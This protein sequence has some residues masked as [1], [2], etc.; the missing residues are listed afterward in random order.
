MDTTTLS[1][2]IPDTTLTFLRLSKRLA[3]ICA[4][5]VLVL[6][7]YYLPIAL[8]IPGWR[9]FVWIGIVL[10]QLLHHKKGKIVQNQGVYFGLWF[11]IIFIEFC[12][13]HNFALFF[14]LPVIFVFLIPSYIFLTTRG[15]YIFLEIFIILYA[16]IAFQKPTFTDANILGFIIV[17]TS[18]LSSWDTFS[19]YVQIQS[20]HV[21]DFLQCYRK[22]TDRFKDNL[23]N[24]W[25]NLL[26]KFD[27]ETRDHSL[28]VANLS[29][30]F[31]QKLGLKPESIQKLKREALLHDIGKLAIPSEVLFKTG[32]LNPEDKDAIKQHAYFSYKFIQNS[33]LLKD[34]RATTYAHHERWDGKG[35]PNGLKG[36][37]IPFRARVLSIAD[38]WDAL[39]SDRT[40][41][42]AWTA[43][44]AKEYLK[45]EAGKQFDPDLVNVFLEYIDDIQN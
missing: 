24:D 45:D 15:L 10:F 29:V 18:L 13:F 38:V 28:R 25:I 35:Y 20:I 2:A 39:T 34:F 22:C 17:S 44:K 14:L 21:K 37:E 9:T 11:G 43:E 36:Y 12:Y 16:W 42:R 30:G 4:V 5:S 19:K 40:Y 3:I 33:P 8:G 31:G 23:I 32:K 6:S 7:L 27:P 26:G 1:S 41:H